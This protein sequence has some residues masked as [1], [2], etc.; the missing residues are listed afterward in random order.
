[1][2]FLDPKDFQKQRKLKVE[3]YVLL[4]RNKIVFSSK[5]T[6]LL[7]LQ[8]ASKEIHLCISDTGEILF[9]LDDRGFLYKVQPHRK[10]ATRNMH[11]YNKQLCQ[12][13]C[14]RYGFED[15][16]SVKMLVV[17][18]PDDNGFYTIIPRKIK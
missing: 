4:Y 8:S 17:D 10:S 6:E 2:Q 7:L 1:M 9:K 18:E 12:F 5:M 13:I 14:D 11:I 3:R 16:K 15:E